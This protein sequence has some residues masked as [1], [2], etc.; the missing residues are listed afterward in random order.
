[1]KLPAI[2]L[3]TVI[4]N[5]LLEQSAFSEVSGAP[6]L[7]RGATEHWLFDK[8]NTD[9]LTG[10]L[11]AGVLTPSAAE[12]TWAANAVVIPN[13]LNGLKTPYHD[14]AA[15]TVTAVVRFNTIVGAAAIVFGAL[16]QNST[17]GGGLAYWNPTNLIA[18]TRGITSSA[19]KVRPAGIADGVW[20]FVA[21]SQS[22]TSRTLMLGGATPVTTAG[23]KTA[24][25]IGKKVSLGNA[26]YNVDGWRQGQHANELAY[27]NRALSIP[28][29]EAVYARAKVRAAR[30]GI[31]V[32]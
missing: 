10:R 29:M 18:L 19:V 15:Q 28:E 16:T 1:M 32:F 7:E 23:V 3:S 2:M 31:A 8:G 14:T 27:F 6:E 25:T 26:Y 30:R 4:D 21:L 12:P 20:A 17:E 22:P 11:A 24:T 13:G 9:G 5:P